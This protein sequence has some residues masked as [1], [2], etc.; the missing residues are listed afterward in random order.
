[1]N[2]LHAGS[3]CLVDENTK[4]RRRSWEYVFLLR[5]GVRHLLFAVAPASS[6]PDLGGLRMALGP[7][8]KVMIAFTCFATLEVAVFPVRH[9]VWPILSA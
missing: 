4:P 5:R 9:S 2:V 1:V 7:S 3:G 8:V 6:A